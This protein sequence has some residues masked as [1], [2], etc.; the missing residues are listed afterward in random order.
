M[1]SQLQRLDKNSCICERNV[2]L[3]YKI[4]FTA[5][6]SF[7]ADGKEKKTPSCLFVTWENRLKHYGK[8]HYFGQ[9]L[10]VQTDIYTQKTSILEKKKCINL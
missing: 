4:D 10:L 7:I 3:Y 8:I 1:K 2:F 9:C 6:Y 5:N